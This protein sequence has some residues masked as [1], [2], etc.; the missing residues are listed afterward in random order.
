MS[1]STAQKSERK[2][3]GNRPAP[4]FSTPRRRLLADRAASMLVTAGGMAIILSILGIL[5]FIV[6]EVVPLLGDAEVVAQDEIPLGSHSASA[7][8]VDD[9]RSLAAT[10][11][12]DGSLRV[13]DTAGKVI[14]ERQVSDAPLEQIKQPPGQE[15]LSGRTA[16]GRVVAAAVDWKVTFEGDQR[17]VTPILFEP[18]VFAFG[19][20]GRSV[21]E[22]T[23]QVDG[24]GGGTAVVQYDDG[25]LRTITRKMKVVEP[26]VLPA[27]WDPSTVAPTPV[28]E[29]HDIPFDTPLQAL[30][31]D[32][33]GLNLYGGTDGGELVW[34]SLNEGAASAPQREQGDAG[35]SALSLLIGDRALVA[36]RADGSLDIWFRVRQPDRSFV[37]TEVR[38]FQALDGAIRMIAPSLRDKSFILQDD[39][40]Q[41]AILHSTSHQVLWRG[42]SPAPEATSL[43][44]APKADGAFFGGQG[45]IASVSIDSPHPEISLKSLF[46]KVWYEGYDKPAYVWQSSSGTND[47]E[48]KLSLTPL[49]IGTLKGTIYSLFLAIP[50]G[51]LGAMFVSQFMHPTY[52]RTIKPT[53]EIMAAL[54]SVVLGFLAGLWLAPRIE[55]IV[56]SL[57]LMLIVLP[58][59]VMAGGLI[60]SRIPSGIRGRVRAGG[61]MWFH[62]VIIV[63]GVG[64]CLAL[65]DTVENLLFAGNFQGWLFESTG[66]PYDQRNA[67]VV[68]IAMG[69]AVIPIIFSIAED[70][71]SNVPRNLV[72]G[73]LALGANRWETV[74]KVV[75]PTASPGIF[76]AII[77][78][79]GRAIG[80]TMIVLMATGNTPVLDWNLFNGFRTLSA[81]IAVEI[82]EAP[83]GGTLYRSLF[84]AALLLFVLTFAVNTLADFIRQRLRQ[85]YAQ[86]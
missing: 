19:E 9:Y 36:G 26:E 28:D 78:G 79:F 48:P 71:L 58:V 67:L 86:L 54:P 66:L 16:D 42:P 4:A 46:G 77:I 75:L 40:G 74:T 52:K 50:L 41:A 27:D 57:F 12:K 81:N 43:F 61:E 3:E 15:L 18:A 7:L 29:L 53:I 22:F 1:E 13:F 44:Y 33:R 51:V 32:E 56:Q 30:M 76:S 35:V 62:M 64:I 37:L 11:S 6:I 70:A 65:N 17:V 14:L 2:A 10:L 63:I 83:Q 38:R 82:P 80:E 21:R 55:F 20:E 39:A 85:R 59:M 84:L 49:M 45:T 73:S 5:F 24:D 34:W 72:S 60:W 47:F 69:F 25:S 31:L 23:V 8:L 68:G